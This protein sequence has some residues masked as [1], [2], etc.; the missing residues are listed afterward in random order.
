LP[1]SF[2]SGADIAVLAISASAAPAEAGAR[3]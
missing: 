2:T 3:Q 1:Q